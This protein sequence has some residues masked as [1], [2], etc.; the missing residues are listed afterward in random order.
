MSR[1]GASLSSQKP[2]TG[3]KHQSVDE[4]RR[5][6]VKKAA[7]VAPAIVVLGLMTLGSAKAQVSGL[8]PPPGPGGQQNLPPNQRKKPGRG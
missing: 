4:N 8:E 3:S 5:K 1:K 7:Y 2:P 6:L